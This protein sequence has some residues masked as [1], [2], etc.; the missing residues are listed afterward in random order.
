MTNPDLR[1]R[2][3]MAALTGLTTESGWDS[4]ADAARE[5]Y[6]YAEAMM[7]ERDRLASLVVREGEGDE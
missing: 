5:A 1:D 6:A 7:A 4:F 2:F 3:A